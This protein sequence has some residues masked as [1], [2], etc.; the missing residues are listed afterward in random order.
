M[1]ILVLTKKGCN[2]C[3]KFK[4]IVKKLSNNYD[5]IVRDAT[6]D[7]KQ[8]YNVTLYPTT[9]VLSDNGKLLNT[10]LGFKEE[11]PLTVEL[12]TSKKLEGMLK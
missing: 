1:K 4:L 11:S 8:K 5:F 7:D 10:I 3:N 12:N 9:V 6:Q 2:W